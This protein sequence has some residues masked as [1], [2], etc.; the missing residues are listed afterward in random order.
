VPL[1]ITVKIFTADKPLIYAFI[2]TQFQHAN[3]F[4]LSSMTF[5]ITN[6]HG[7]KWLKNALHY[8]PNLLNPLAESPSPLLIPTSIN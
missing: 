3:V 8:L 2:Y 7:I 6:L 5:P 1:V 4:R